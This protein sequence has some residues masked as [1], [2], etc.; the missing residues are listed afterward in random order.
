MR[1]A[2]SLPCAV[3]AGLFS[4]AAAAQEL[5][6]KA[7][8]H[9]VPGSWP[10]YTGD[11]SGR[12]FSPLAQVNQTTISR[13]NLKWSFAAGIRSSTE[14]VPP[15]KS[16][17]LEVEGVLYFTLPDHAWAVDARTGRQLWHFAWKSGGGIHIGNRG[18]G[19]YR[20][21]LYLETPDNHLVSL[22]KTTGKLRWS[23][24]IADLDQEYFSTAAPLII[25]NHVITGVGGDSLDVPAY[26]ESRDPETG[27]VQWHFDV[28]PKPGDPAFATWPNAEA[29]SHGGGMTWLSGTYD[30]ELNL[31]YFGT[32]NPNP[33][34]SGRSRQGDNLYT[35]T[36][37][38]LNP[39]TGKLA[40]YFQV[41]PHDTHD[42]DSVQTPVLFDA[43]IGG[44]QRK[45]LAQAS[46]NGYFIVLDRTNGRNILSKPYVHTN[47]SK[48]VNANG[49]PIP[50]A[51]KEATPD[52]VLVA[53]AVAA[54][55]WPPPTFDPETGLFYV[56]SNEGYQMWYLTDTSDRPQGFAG[57]TTL[58]ASQPVLKAIDTRSGEIR[59]SH[60]YSAES[61]GGMGGLLT[62]A[63]NLL[64]AGDPTNHFIAFDPTNGR[65]LWHAGLIA[66][67]SNGPMTYELDG[68][69]YIVV[70]GGDTLYCFGLNE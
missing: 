10:T 31:Y 67:V 60:P 34:Y 70:A 69:Q 20:D 63:G 52:G 54:A 25:G 51:A 30:P 23:V 41:S 12:R 21:W 3:L 46:R 58:I 42:W 9:P 5:D 66:P 16:T 44:V 19:I 39:D 29:A 11:Y 37:L 8:A 64:F 49:N 13:L 47:W 28:D 7:I 56:N 1:I 55:N 45:L 27:K 40:W 17:P 2:R 35:A 50:D 57:S 22:D 53:P 32:G 61:D 38:A 6:P 62:T 33:V 24:E 65:I 36:I 48:G 4:L 15:I 14:Y 26:L 43:K 59:W 68:R 18:V